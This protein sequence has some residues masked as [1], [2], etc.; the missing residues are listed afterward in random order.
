M[1]V[2]L[3]LFAVFRLGIVTS[4]C[5]DSVDSVVE[6]CRVDG[7]A[8][9]GVLASFLLRAALAFLMSAISAFSSRSAVC[10]RSLT[11]LASALDVRVMKTRFT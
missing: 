3:L 2:L 1:L 6:L 8:S 4:F 11:I 9:S 7:W 10:W 5:F